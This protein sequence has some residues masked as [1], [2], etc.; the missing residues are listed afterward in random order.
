MTQPASPPDFVHP[1]LADR[2]R[3]CREAKRWTQADLAR[4]A[5]LSRT[6]VKTIED[7]QA[8]EPSARTIGLLCL[9]LQV[10]VIDLMQ[11]ARALPVDYRQSQIQTEL[12]M[13][14]YLR[15]QRR[16][17]EQFVNTL[18]RLIRLAEEDEHGGERH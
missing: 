17:S 16:L 4:R 18:M 12:D 7:G 1:S 13:T 15:R 9:A 11:A 8:K 3:S 6:Y 2:V 14:M 5:G 10:D